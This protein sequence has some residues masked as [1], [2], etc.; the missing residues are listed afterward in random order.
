MQ[1]LLFIYLS[2]F[3]RY[4][5]PLIRLNIW[6]LI[7]TRRDKLDRSCHSQRKV[8]ARDATKEIVK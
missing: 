6:L 4:I 3:S 8:Q 1:F 7:E 5:T 2:F